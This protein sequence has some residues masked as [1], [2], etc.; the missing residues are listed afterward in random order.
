MSTNN[1]DLV[2]P[3]NNS[4]P[5]SNSNNCSNIHKLSVIFLNIQGLMNKT[6][7]LD[8]FLLGIGNSYIICLSEHW[9]SQDEVPMSCPTGYY[10][11][12]SFC[13]SNH[14]R[15]GTLIFV[16][17][18]FQSRIC[19]VS[20]FCSELHLEASAA[21]VDGLKILVVSVYHSTSGNPDIFLDCFEKLLIHLSKYSNYSILIGGDFNINFDVT[22]GSKKASHL[23]NLLRQYGYH[24]KNVEPTRGKHCLDNVFV[25]WC[26]KL[27][28]Q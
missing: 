16:H 11:A 18:I 6:L 15:G 13:R 24:F 21:F 8:S 17:K 4:N 19:D 7:I 2:S 23:S 5:K 12:S 27:H 28:V 22:I 3:H 20:D 1:S 9:L 25:K 10:C 14:I 26:F